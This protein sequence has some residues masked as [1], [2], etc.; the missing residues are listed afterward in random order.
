MRSLGEQ[1][2]P[3]A[4]LQL[5]SFVTKVSSGLKSPVSIVNQEHEDLRTSKLQV[6]FA[7]TQLAMPV[8]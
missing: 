5:E 3:T 8:I 7:R 1:L 2:K 4:L 6:S